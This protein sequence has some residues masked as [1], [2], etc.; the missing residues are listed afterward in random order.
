MMIVADNA[1]VSNLWISQHENL[2]PV[3][4]VYF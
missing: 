3:E 2:L 1:L 4:V